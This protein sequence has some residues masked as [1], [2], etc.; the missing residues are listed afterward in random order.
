MSFFDEDEEPL[1]TTSRTRSQPRPRRGSPAG[2]SRTDSQSVLVRRMVFVFV[3]LFFVIIVGAFVKSCSSN[4]H[5][6]SLRS[7]NQSVSQIAGTSE[8]LGAQFFRQLGQGA[9]QSPQA[10]QGQV[11]SFRAQADTQLTQA[12][13]LSTPSEM[14]QAQQSLLL[15]LE[16]RRD[17]LES[18]AAEIRT[19]LGDQGNQADQAIK[20]IAGQ[21]QY[22][23][24]S[25]VLYKARVKPFI[26]QALDKANVGA[27]TTADSQFLKEISW[28]S[29]AYVASKL[30]QQLSS[31]SS[32]SGSTTQQTTGPGLHGTG[33]N[34]TSYGNVTLS[35]G[36]SNR[37]TYVS[38]QAFSVAFTNQ[39]DNEEFNVKVTL[40]ILQNNKAVITLDKTVPSIVKGQKATVQLPLTR[41]PPTESAVVVK[42]TVATVPGEKKKDNNTASY[43]SLFVTG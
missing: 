43:P 24:A 1:R 13:A 29:P 40:Q 42:V 33:L 9:N 6:D 41:T 5:K 20:D 32:G 25:D 12:K 27:Q 22:F 18:I 39:G 4:R 2:L 15:A 11:S 34:A 21:M 19:A 16:L 3:I 35:S 28:V 30:G 31:T 36:A 17:G 26:K 7:Y 38:G 14:Q 23:N 37:L 10:L 8:Q